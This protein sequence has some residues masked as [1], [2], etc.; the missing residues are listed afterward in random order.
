[1]VGGLAPAGFEKR[2]VEQGWK[3]HV[4]G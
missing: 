3:G 1:V 4:Q 2:V